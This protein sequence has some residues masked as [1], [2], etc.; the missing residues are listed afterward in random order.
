MK[1]PVCCAALM[2]LAACNPQPQ[3]Q[4]A[5]TPSATPS[6]LPP[7][8]IRGRGTIREPVRV[9]GQQHG[10]TAYQL[11]AQS[12][13]SHSVQSVTQAVFAQTQVTFYD[14]DGTRLQARAPQARLDDHR[15]QVIL[16]G[17]VHAKTSSG[18]TLVCDE[19][20]YDDASGMLHGTGHVRITG[21]QGGQTQV[22]TGN[23]FTSDV[24]LTQMTMR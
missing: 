23:S 11:L 4:T 22:L 24:K 5:A 16:S 13:E 19:L 6:E 12:Y 20:V 2:L 14:K 18:L 9:T 15:K 1:W 21:M 7:I 17:G 8:T 3:H 10:R